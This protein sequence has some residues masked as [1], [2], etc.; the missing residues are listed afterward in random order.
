[1]RL[2]NQFILGLLGALTSRLELRFEDARDSRDLASPLLGLCV[3]GFASIRGKGVIFR[4]AIVLC[5]T[6]LRLDPAC[7]FQAAESWKQRSGIHQENAVADLLNSQ[8]YPVTMHGL[9]NQ[10]LKDQHFQS[11]LDQI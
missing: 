10:S 4:A 2:V 11:S 6:P 7:A 3:E 8:S 1:M 9:K 5:G